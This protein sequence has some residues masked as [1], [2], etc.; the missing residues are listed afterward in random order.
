MQNVGENQGKGEKK[1]N[2]SLKSLFNQPHA[3]SIDV[4]FL[5]YCVRTTN[6]F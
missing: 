6:I 2:G 5:P 4:D 3:Q 1:G